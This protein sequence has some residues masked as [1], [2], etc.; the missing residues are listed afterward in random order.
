MRS[1]KNYVNGVFVNSIPTGMIKAE[2]RWGLVGKYLNGGD[3]DRAPSKPLPLAK[4]EN[5]PDRS[6]PD[7]F[8]FVWLGHSSVLMQIDG[9]TLL[10]DPMFSKRASPIQWIGP[11]RFQPAPVKPDDLPRLDAVLISHDHYDHLDKGT[12]T[13]IAV[14]TQ[15]FYVPLGVAAI[16]EKWG[17][18]K[19]KIIEMDWWDESTAS[20]LRIAATPARHFSGRGLF[21]RFSTLWCSFVIVGRREKI[22]FSG[23]TGAT[24]DFQAISAK[25]G[26]FEVAFIKMAAYNE[27]WPDIHLTPEQAIEAHRDLKGKYFVPIHWGAFDLGLHSWYEPIER[28]L[29]AGQPENV[30]IIAPKMG[31]TV[32]VSTF[33]NTYWWRGL[34]PVHVAKEKSRP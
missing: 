17:I 16:L 20:G 11:Q 32:D 12:I 19:E 7:A 31:E 9:K 22:F 25:Y 33:D 5:F 14:K 6:H 23:D 26:P 28:L 4:M 3:D 15:R 24:P 10:T 34:M 21:D 27:A 30:R 18:D 8:R 2:K 1:S 29:K 13:K